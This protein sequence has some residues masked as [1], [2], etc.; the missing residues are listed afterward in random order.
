MSVS[1]LNRHAFFVSLLLTHASPIFI[2]AGSAMEAKSEIK[3]EEPQKQKRVSLTETLSL[4]E[5]P[6]TVPG[7]DSGHNWRP[8]YPIRRAGAL[9]YSLP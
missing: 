1:L 9:S 5:D 2:N 6:K 7:T 8:V 3:S 4:F